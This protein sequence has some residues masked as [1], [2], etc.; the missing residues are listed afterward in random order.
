MNPELEDTTYRRMYPTGASLPKLYG[1][2]KY[3]RTTPWGP[4]IQAEALWHMG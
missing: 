3:T 1:L 4:L 2:P